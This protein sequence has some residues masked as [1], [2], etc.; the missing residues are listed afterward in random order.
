MVTDIPCGTPAEAMLR[1]LFLNLASLPGLRR[2]AG[3]E[4][5]LK[6]TYPTLADSLIMRFERT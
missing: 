2:A 1:A 5:A 6:Q 4:G 3:P